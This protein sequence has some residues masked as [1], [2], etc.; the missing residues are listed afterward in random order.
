MRKAMNKLKIGLIGGG[1]I[2]GRHLECLK[3]K[4]NYF[5]IDSLTA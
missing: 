3:T 1:H 2:S 4:S 5:L